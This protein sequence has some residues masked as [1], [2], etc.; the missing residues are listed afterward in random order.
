M[1]EIE[2]DRTMLNDKPT[3]AEVRDALAI[4]SSLISLMR[5]GCINQSAIEE[6]HAK[7]MA[8]LDRAL[9]RKGAAG[10]IE[11]RMTE[12]GSDDWTGRL[13]VFFEDCDIPGPQRGT[14]V[15]ALQNTGVYRVI[16]QG[17][18]VAWTLTRVL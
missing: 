6:R 17:G 9:G 13:D 3:Y 2:K 7:V 1:L 5:Q 18:F 15:A 12:A 10:D 8:V 14:I 4:A 11:V 16:G